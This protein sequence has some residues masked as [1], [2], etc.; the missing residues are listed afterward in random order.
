MKMAKNPVQR[1][2]VEKVES[3]IKG[4]VVAQIG[5]KTLILGRNGIGKSAI[6]NSIEAA[7]TGKVSD[8]AGRA[9]LARDADLFMLA[10]PGAE[11]VWAEVRFAEGKG[12]ARWELT[13]GK[14][15]KRTGPAIAFPL[16]DV[17]DA[18]LGSP[19]TAR[20]WILAHGGDF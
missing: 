8:V 9:L 13:K 5:H 10:P 4:S 12:T 1:T 6:L 16:R 20:K 11:K 15:A 14:R 17:Q 2:W 3:S 19:E 7:G 18:L